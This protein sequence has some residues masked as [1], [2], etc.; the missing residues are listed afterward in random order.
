M[1]IAELLEQEKIGY[2]TSEAYWKQVADFLKNN[3]LNEVNLILL[4]IMKV[5]FCERGHFA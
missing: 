2:L 1:I 3:Y 4:I 5:S